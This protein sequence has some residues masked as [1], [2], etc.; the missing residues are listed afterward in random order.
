MK[1]QNK[2]KRREK[3]RKQQSQK[4]RCCTMTRVTG[5][6]HQQDCWEEVKET[7]GETTKEEKLDYGKLR[8][9]PGRLL[10]Q[11]NLLKM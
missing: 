5:C 9:K 7:K 10:R 1:K 2:L 11:A 8:A 6:V 3:K 4:F